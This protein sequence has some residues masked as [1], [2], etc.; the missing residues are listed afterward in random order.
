MNVPTKLAAFA[1]LSAA[2][3]AAAFGVGAAVGPVDAPD[4]PATQ[5]PAADGSQERTPTVGHH[6]RDGRHSDGAGR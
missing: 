5:R 2:V 6:D 3:F 1:A 4:R